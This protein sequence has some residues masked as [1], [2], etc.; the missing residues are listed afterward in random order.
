MNFKE[1]IIRKREEY[2][3]YNQVPFE[4]ENDTSNLFR[5]YETN[6][7]VSQRKEPGDF[8]RISANQP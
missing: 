4:K 3:N 6:C 5:Y 7:R 8:Q 1:R 2:A